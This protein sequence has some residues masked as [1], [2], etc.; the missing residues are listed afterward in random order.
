MKIPTYFCAAYHGDAE[1]AQQF[2]ANI[3]RALGV[4]SAVE[5]AFPGIDLFVPHRNDALLCW[6]WRR[7]FITS[8]QITEVC[9]TIAAEKRLIIVLEPIG[10]GMREEIE[11]AC[12]Y[13]PK[14]V[15]YIDEWNETAKDTIAAAIAKCRTS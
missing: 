8:A 12:C 7:G 15:V 11:Y 9:C 1:T 6:C 13:P 3:M 14:D 2:E 4:A 10:S 5:C